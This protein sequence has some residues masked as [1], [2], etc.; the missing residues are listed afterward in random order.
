MRMLLQSLAF[1]IVFLISTEVLAICGILVP[2]WVCSSAG[3][4]RWEFSCADRQAPAF[5]LEYE[6]IRLALNNDSVG[7][8]RYWRSHDLDM[9][10]YVTIVVDGYIYGE[11][12]RVFTTL[13]QQNTPI[14]AQTLACR[15]NNGNWFWP[16]DVHHLL[17]HRRLHFRRGQPWEILHVSLAASP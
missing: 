4:C 11:W 13:V 14:S 10:R 8:R 6:N 5:V 7:M 12:C 9:L 1:A 2:R 3:S 17:Y 15:D 16:V